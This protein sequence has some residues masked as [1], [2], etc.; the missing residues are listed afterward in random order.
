MLDAGD[1]YHY[2]TAG[3]QVVRCVRGNGTVK[4]VKDCTMAMGCKTW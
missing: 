4:M 1:Y 2:G 3:P